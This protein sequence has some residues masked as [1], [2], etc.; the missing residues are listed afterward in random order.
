[1]TTITQ[2]ITAPPTAPSRADPSTFATRADA[3]VSWQA[4]NATQLNT[5]SGQI[6]TVAG[7]VNTN[8]TNAQAAQVAAETA[9]TAAENAAALVDFMGTY[10]GGTTYALG[11]SVYYNG[12][13]WVSLQAGNTGNTPAGGSA[14]WAQTLPLN[15]PS[16][17]LGSGWNIDCNA[18]FSDFTKTVASTD[19]FTLSNVPSAGVVYTF[20]LEITYTSGTI[21]FF[22]GYTV[23]WPEALGDAA[24]TFVAGH[25][26]KIAFEIRGGTTVVDV[27]GLADFD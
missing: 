7:E 17:A 18:G 11:E 8:R 14:W 1:M 21:T 27:I 3:H 20:V 22:S 15:L 23:N 9:Q 16:S 25:R 10:A 13:Y 4:T 12:L 5:L 19:A 6:N 2:T 26:Y 24:P